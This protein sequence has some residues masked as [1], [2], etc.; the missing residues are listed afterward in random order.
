MKLEPRLA[1][2]DPA[3]ALFERRGLRRTGESLQVAQ[4]RI[5]DLADDDSLLAGFDK[6][7][8]YAVRR[9]EREG[10]VVTTT[11]DAGDLAAIDALH[12]L[13]GETQ[14]RA[15]F[16]MPALERYRIA[17]ARAGRVRGRP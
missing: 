11:D 13:V 2:D 16:P 3:L 15:G 14:A 17:W 4:T 10:V 6:D 12:A 5:V 9:A 7:T 1:A 8:R